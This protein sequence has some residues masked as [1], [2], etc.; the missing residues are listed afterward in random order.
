[1]TQFSNEQWEQDMERGVN[2]HAS[3]VVENICDRVVPLAIDVAKAKARRKKQRR[4]HLLVA[5]LSVCVSAISVL[6][7]FM[8]IVP[9]DVPYYTAPIC[10]G[11]CVGMTV[12]EIEAVRK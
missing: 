1:M 10:L 2:D 6:L 12:A 4:I 8:N 7:Q 5:W 11:V 9:P 3:R